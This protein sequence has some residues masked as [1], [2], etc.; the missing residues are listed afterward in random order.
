RATVRFPMI[1]PPFLPT[2]IRVN[3]GTLAF[4]RAWGPLAPRRACG[5]LASG[6][7]R[8]RS[9]S[10]ELGDRG[11]LGRV[12]ERAHEE[13]LDGGA[14]VVAQEA[15]SGAREV[16]MRD[17]G[18]PHPL[19]R[20]SRPLEP[21][22]LVLIEHVQPLV[23]ELGVFRA[24][25]GA[26]HHGTVGLDLAHEEDV[27]AVVHLMPDALQ[28]LPE[29]RRIGVAPVHQ[30]ADVRQAHVAVL[31]LGAGEHAEASCPGVAVAL[32]GEVHL[33]DA[34]A[35]RG[36]AECCLG[37]LRGAAEEDAFFGLHGVSS[38]GALF[39]IPA[40]PST[41]RSRTTTGREI[42]RWRAARRARAA[43]RIWAGHGRWPRTGRRPGQSSPGRAR[44]V[45]WP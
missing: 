43:P 14:A 42:T 17:D 24:H 4:R 12:P 33:L 23:E 27:L 35:L 18:L 1:P 40:A 45:R 36:L 3:R 2:A 29:E 7:S 41:R 28:D 44:G 22:V 26:A 5:T 32:E 6:P 13:A 11:L 19:P 37:A 39:P 34:V 8:G 9:P 25:A 16:G 31:Q 30:L 38:G 21:P 20:L 10:G 15:R